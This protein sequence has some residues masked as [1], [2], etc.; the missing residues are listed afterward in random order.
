MAGVLRARRSHSEARLF[1]EEPVFAISERGQVAS[2]G[3]VQH[4]KVLQKL[5]AADQV[6]CL[7]HESFELFRVTSLCGAHHVS[8]GRSHIAP[9]EEAL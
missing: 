3:V 8:S 2:N 1:F 9:A 4:G 7:W 6:R 5:P